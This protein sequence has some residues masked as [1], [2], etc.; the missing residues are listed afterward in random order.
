MAA[1]PVPGAHCEPI[2]DQS[3]LVGAECPRLRD[4]GG[5][6]LDSYCSASCVL[7]PRYSA[8]IGTSWGSHK[9][10]QARRSE[11]H[12]SE[13]QSLM[14]ISS[15]VFCLNK[16]ITTNLSSYYPMP[17]STSITPVY[18]HTYMNNFVS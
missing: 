1:D 6:V 3:R 4:P 7:V 14:R 2:V 16:Q 9:P 13:L 18:K 15:D 17:H 8:R 11:E 5:A 12:T 10:E